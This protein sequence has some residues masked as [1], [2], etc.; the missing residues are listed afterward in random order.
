[1]FWE[2]ILFF[3]YS[4]LIVIISKYILVKLLRK[5]AVSLN[6]SSKTVGNIAGIATSVPEFLTVSFSALAGLASTSIFNILSS[7]IINTCQYALAII[8]NKNQKQL[9]NKAIRI[10][11]TLVAITIF[12]PII[13]LITNIEF[14]WYI[15]PIFIFLFIFFYYINFNAHKLY[16]KIEE[17][18]ES[19]RKYTKRKIGMIAVYTIY[20]LITTIALYFVGDRL[21]NALQNLADIF[22]IPELVLGIMLGFITSLPELITFF[23]SQRHH[24]EDREG[25]IE[26]TNNLFA[27][28]LLNLFVIQSI[29][30]IIMNLV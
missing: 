24:K 9:N 14:R 26:A 27:S 23:E 5:L 28:N 8:L 20:L 21:S 22:K 25:V 12:I 19:K 10:Q 2:I 1:M 4:I 11:L 15:V 6:L 17:Q 30:I 3:V 29:G 18:K 13:M 7:N 16:L